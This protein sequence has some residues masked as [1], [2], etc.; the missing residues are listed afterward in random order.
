MDPKGS[1]TS[2]ALRSQTIASLSQ[3]SRSCL[4]CHRRKV[5]C[6][7]NAP[8]SNCVQ[9]KM[10]CQYPDLKAEENMRKPRR[11]PNMLQRIERLERAVATLA[12]TGKIKPS[13]SRQLSSTPSTT[14]SSV[15][16]TIYEDHSARQS[17]DYDNT[18][19]YTEDSTSPN[20]TTEEVSRGP[21]PEVS[22]HH[23]N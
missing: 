15:P 11:A 7:K 14:S 20:L 1:R 9:R 17:F 22:F 8:C 13:A 2:D 12:D 21:G 4:A 5:K 10:S 16:P 3:A 23:I 19:E 18:T 6:D